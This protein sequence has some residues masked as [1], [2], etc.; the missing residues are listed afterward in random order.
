MAEGRRRQ[1]RAPAERAI[2][3]DAPAGVQIGRPDRLEE[4]QAIGARRHL[5]TEHHG[6]IGDIG[7]VPRRHAP[8]QAAEVGLGERGLGDA[9]HQAAEEQLAVLR[10]MHF[11]A[12]GRARR[13]DVDHVGEEVK[14]QGF[15]VPFLV[16]RDRAGF[17]GVEGIV[18]VDRER[19][20]HI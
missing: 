3:L 4:D 8:A 6:H 12:I 7:P 9:V 14:R 2:R 13:R 20:G 1:G 19:E 5:E 11:L 18:P 15:L 17:D 10:D 16:Q